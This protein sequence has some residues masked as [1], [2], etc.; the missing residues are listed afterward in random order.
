MIGTYPVPT[1]LI[2]LAVTGIFGGGMSFFYEETQPGNLWVPG[3][4]DAQIHRDWIETNYPADYLRF[5][6]LI[7]EADNVLDP[8][9]IKAVSVK[10]N[11]F[12]LFFSF[13]ESF[14]C[15]QVHSCIFS[16]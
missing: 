5:Q 7:I 11:F 13:S 8:K 2:C 4:S 14:Y 15:V 1:I 3:D 6:F 10:C 16:F 12:S 9:V